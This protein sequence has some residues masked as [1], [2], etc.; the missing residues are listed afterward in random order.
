MEFGFAPIQSEPTF[1][2]M[3][4][5]ARLA[6]SLGFDALWA[7]EHVRTAREINLGLRPYSHGRRRGACGHRDR[8]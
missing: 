2:A 5:Q 6:E 8:P 1:E 7:H 3:S 4:R